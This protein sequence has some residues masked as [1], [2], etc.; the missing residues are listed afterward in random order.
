[1]VRVTLCQSHAGKMLPTGH[2][3]TAMQQTVPHT[4]IGDNLLRIMSPAAAG[5][6]VGNVDISVDFEKQ[7]IYIFKP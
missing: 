2:E 4:G 7:V 6:G 3:A 1:M 5:Q